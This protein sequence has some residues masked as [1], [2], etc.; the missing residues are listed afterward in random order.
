M[1]YEAQRPHQYS[2][3]SFILHTLYFILS[4]AIIP[5][6]NNH[7]QKLPSFVETGM[8]ERSDDGVLPLLQDITPSICATLDCHPFTSEWGISGR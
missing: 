4:S 5:I 2:S 6:P 7:R 3:Q 8:S 1:K